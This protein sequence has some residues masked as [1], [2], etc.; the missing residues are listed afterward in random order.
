VTHTPPVPRITHP[1]QHRQQARLIRG[2]CGQLN[3]V[4]GI[5]Q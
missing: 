2:F 1:G 3:Q 5:D 4:A